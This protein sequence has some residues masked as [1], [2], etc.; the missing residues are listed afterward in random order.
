MSQFE[1]CEDHEY[2]PISDEKISELVTPHL[3]VLSPDRAGILTTQLESGLETLSCLDYYGD[4][5]LYV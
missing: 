1:Q 2:L 3:T 4:R 5:K